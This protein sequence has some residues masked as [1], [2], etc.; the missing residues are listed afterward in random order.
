MLS[1]LP[2]V[3]S[4]GMANWCE[5]AIV[6]VTLELIAWYVAFNHYLAKS[7]YLKTATMSCA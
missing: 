1:V 2:A 4:L 7:E 6:V 3:Y 5:V